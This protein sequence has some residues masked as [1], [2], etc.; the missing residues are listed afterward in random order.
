[1]ISKETVLRT[2]SHAKVPPK[3]SHKKCVKNK[4]ATMKSGKTRMR[5]AATTRTRMNQYSNDIER[6]VAKATEV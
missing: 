6:A 2:R 3:N 5:K 4:H 1:M